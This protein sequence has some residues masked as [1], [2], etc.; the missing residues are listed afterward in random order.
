LGR[1]SDLKKAFLDTVPVLTGYV[2]LGIGFGIILKTKG[3]GAGWALA[4]SLFIYAGSLQYV[5][6]DLLTGGASLLTA[7]FT[8]L[9]VNARHL[10]YGISMIDRYKGA[11]RKK[12]YLMFALTDET[13]SLVCQDPVSSDP[14][15]RAVRHRYY[16]TVSFF[17]QCYWVAGSVIGSVL[18]A[19]IPF[20]TEGIDFALTALFVTIFVEQWLSAKDHRPALAGLGASLVCLFV[21]GPGSF[22]IPAMIAITLL[23]TGMRSSIE[24]GGRV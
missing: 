24:K 22:L 23:L 4:M 11:G 16:L 21:F 5:V 6:I 9:M 1:K 10:F 8:S 19:I 12:P 3:Y 20:N 18:G 15:E 7:A 17:N 14:S 13:Y 2:V